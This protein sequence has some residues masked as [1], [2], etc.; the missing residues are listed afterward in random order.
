VLPIRSRLPLI[1]LL[2]NYLTSYN[3]MPEWEVMV[4]YRLRE[5]G[6]IR[7]DLA[8]RQAWTIHPDDRG[9]RFEKA[10]PRIIARVEAGDYPPEQGGRY[11]LVLDRWL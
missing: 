2:R 1:P 3:T 4:G 8:T 11:D 10:L 9:E 7:G 5:V 6:M